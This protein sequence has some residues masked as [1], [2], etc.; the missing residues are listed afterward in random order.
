MVIAP[1]PGST[2][3]SADGLQCRIN[4]LYPVTRDVTPSNHPASRRTLRGVVASPICLTTEVSGITNSVRY[5]QAHPLTE[6]AS[7]HMER[8]WCGSN[9]TGGCVLRC[10]P[11]LRLTVAGVW[12]ELIDLCYVLCFFVSATEC[13]SHKS[14][15]SLSYTATRQPLDRA[16]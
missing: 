12:V 5:Q 3:L 11:P 8:D 16:Y 1:S 14:H 6:P 15:L 9:S 13:R 4:K 2:P 7:F 10:S